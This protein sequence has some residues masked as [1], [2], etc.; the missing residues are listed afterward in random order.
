MFQLGGGGEHLLC[1]LFF[2]YFKFMSSTIFL[3]SF[4]KNFVK[5]LSCP[6]LVFFPKFLL[7]LLHLFTV[8]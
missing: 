6:M 3:F 7:G 5:Y 2:V 1:S 4:L 8:F